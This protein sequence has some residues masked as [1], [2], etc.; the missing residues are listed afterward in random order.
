MATD[1]QK[2]RRRRID[3]AIIDRLARRQGRRASATLD[4]GTIRNGRV[5]SPDG[6]DMS[7]RFEVKPT[8]IPR[9]RWY[10]RN[11]SEM[12]LFAEEN[13][14]YVW[15][16]F[17]SCATME[18]HWADAGLT[19]SDFARLMF[20]GTYTNY[21]GVLCHPNGRMISKDSLRELV[22]IHRTK[23]D[24]FYGKLIAAS[25]IREAEDGAIQMS[26]DVFQRGEIPKGEYIDRIRIY[27]DAVRGLY[28]KY[29]KGRSVRQLG[30]VYSVIPFMHRNLNIICFN[31][32]E[33]ND[34]QIRPITLDKLAL[35]LGYQDTGKFKRAL[36]A[37]NIGS[38]PVFAFVEDVEDSRKRRILVNPRVVF[39]G[40]FEGL[41]A[42]RAIAVEFN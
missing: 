25:I 9:V 22:G 7:H 11:R 37:I 1:Q 33:K 12:G 40:D 28:D 30:I 4:G 39:A 18:M 36:R 16:L 23:F 34:D 19:Q 32:L 8:V 14:G 29:G 26:P 41:M 2:R 17:K 38:Q 24:E 10:F 13:G 31:P 21:E 15:G 35:M 20:I 27:R 6:V 42:C 3:Q 5:I